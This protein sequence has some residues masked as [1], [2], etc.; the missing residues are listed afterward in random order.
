MRTFGMRL[1]STVLAACMIASAFSVSAFAAGENTDTE[2]AASA[3]AEEGMSV[4]AV[5][6][7]IDTGGTY[8]IDQETYTGPIVI[9]TT[10]NVTLN[11]TGDVQYTG[12]YKKASPAFVQVKKV[13]MLAINNNGNTVTCPDES[14]A[15]F[16]NVKDASAVNVEGG[17]YKTS[18]T[19]PGSSAPAFS[20]GAGTVQL[21]NITAW[22]KQN[23]A[24][25]NEGADVSADGCVFSSKYVSAVD[26]RAGSVAL[27]NVTA[28]A[29]EAD[30]IVTYTGASTTVNSGAYSSEEYYVVRSR[31]VRNGG[32]INGGTTTLNGGTYTAG[33]KS[34]I[35]VDCGSVTV[36]GGTYTQ[37]G[38]EST[39]FVNDNGMV[40]IHGG[41]FVCNGTNTTFTNY[42]TLEIDEEQGTTSISHTKT[43][44][45]IAN[46]GVLKFKN[47][48]VESKTIAINSLS[49]SKAD[50]VTEVSGGRIKNSVYGIYVGVNAA[51]TILGGASFESNTN[52]IYLENAQKI[53]IEDTFTGSA[54]VGC[55]DA[56]EGRQITTT[57]S[58]S[59]YQKKLKL[60]S[61][62]GFE[63]GYKKSAE[64]EYRYLTKTLTYTVETKC[65]SAKADLD[66]D[67][68]EETQLDN[69]NNNLL[70]G[71]KIEL[72]ADKASENKEFSQWELLVDGVDKT[73]ELLTEAEKTSPEADFKMPAGN[74]VATAK[75]RDIPTEPEE[76]SEPTEP[77]EPSEPEAPA[78]AGSSDDSGVIIAAAGAA[79]WGA[80]ELGA[81]IYR[82][83][84]GIPYWPSNRAELADLIWERAGKPEPADMST[85]Y[86]DIDKDDTD[87][88]KAAHWMVEQELLKDDKNAKKNT[89]NFHPYR[90]VTKVRVCIT[91]GDAKQ[92][93][94]LK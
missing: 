69:T 18:S 9:D 47:G 70:E 90:V 42:G 24:I 40:Y 6:Q 15:G 94:L 14:G 13:G 66:G 76:P 62:D 33:G 21:K 37:N 46:S 11:I 83:A 39:V 82:Y 68:T 75:Y 20:F 60:T 16:L 67:S 80:Y 92:K 74:V 63:V 31:D 10:D 93:G 59:E 25:Y 23:D 48:T 43:G 55:R 7:T 41:E 3:Q 32:N 51:K 22:T 56:A 36:N 4:A 12:A 91:W 64:G 49:S 34:L 77:S 81:G 35:E 45:A 88:Q 38:S 85:L 73:N 30:V 65:A 29:K 89:D 58:G 50:V 8:R 87:L 1:V 28:S 19:Q 57:T 84:W 53:T 79:A 17:V 61:T 44:S 72:T 5:G 71:T 26:N 86:G 2:N 78:D 27:T 52:D 54:N